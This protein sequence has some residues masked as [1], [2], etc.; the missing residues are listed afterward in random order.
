MTEEQAVA[1]AIPTAPHENHRLLFD[2]ARAVKRLEKQ[3]GREYSDREMKQIFFNPWY[4]RST[5]F[6]R[7]DQT[8]DGYWFEFQEAYE[9]AKYPLGEDVLGKAWARVWSEP[10]PAEAHEFDDEE[11]W[12]LVALCRNLQ[13]ATGNAPFFLSC[14]TVQRLLCKKFEMDA[15]RLLKGLQRHGLLEEAEKGSMAGR[16]AT[17]WWFVPLR[18]SPAAAA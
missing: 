17:R 3:R 18:P 10:P 16:R 14:R 15:H 2:L 5:A 4:D 11:T 12:R 8:K 9:R 13:A 6:L 1:L 7:P